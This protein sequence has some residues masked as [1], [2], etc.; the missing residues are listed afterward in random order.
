MTCLLPTKGRPEAGLLD[1]AAW[2]FAARI[3]CVKGD[4]SYQS[5]GET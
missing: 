1:A 3:A 2:T 4:R 5:L